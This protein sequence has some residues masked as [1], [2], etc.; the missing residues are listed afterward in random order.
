M[1]NG[2]S[3]GRARRTQPFHAIVHQPVNINTQQ[4]L[5]DIDSIVAQC[6]S[7]NNAPGS[8]AP[9]QAEVDDQ[10]YEKGL[11]MDFCNVTTPGPS[12]SYG[13]SVATNFFRF[14]QL[15]THLYVYNLEMIRGLNTA[16][17]EIR[18][19]KK[20][21]KLLV[22]A[23]LPA[24]LPILGANLNWASDGTLLYSTT[25]LYDPSQLPNVLNSGP[26]QYHNEKFDQLPILDVRMSLAETIAMPQNTVDLFYAPNG[27]KRD[28][29]MQDRLKN[30]L[31][32]FLTS[33]ARSRPAN[34]VTIGARGD[35]KLF[36]TQH[37]NAITYDQS[38][39]VI[40]LHRQ[41]DNDAP[42]DL[43]NH[44]KSALRALRG[45]VLSVRPGSNELLVNINTAT[46]PFFR[47]ITLGDYFRIYAN[48]NSQPSV[49]GKSLLGV[50]VRIMYQPHAGPWP[51]PT[52]S[53][54]FVAE[55]GRP[56]NQQNCGDPSVRN[57]TVF[58]WYTHTGT[59]HQSHELWPSARLPIQR[60]DICINVG[61][62]SRHNEGNGAVWIP[63]HQLQIVEY[64][65]FRGILGA[66]ETT[67]MVNAA[68]RDSDL[69]MQHI[70]TNALRMLRLTGNPNP[71][72]NFSVSIGHIPISVP[73]RWLV[74]P[75][76]QYGRTAQLPTG[77]A[78]VRQASWNLAGV[79]FVATGPVA[80]LAA[81]NCTGRNM[82][83]EVGELRRRLN[84][85]GLCHHSI[86]ITLQAL[87]VHMQ[88]GPQLEASILR[89][90]QRLPISTNLPTIFFGIEKGFDIYSAIKRVA[91]LQLGR[92]TV[93]STLGNT[94]P[95]KA[96]NIATKWN[97]K[98]G[99]DNHRLGDAAFACL[100]PRQV[101]SPA[102]TMVLG[103]D[104]THPGPSAET[105]CPSIAAVVGSVDDNFMQ[106]PGSMRLQRGRQEE[107]AELFDMVKE[108][109]VDW[110]TA[111]QRLPTRILFYRDGVSESQYETLRSYEI[112]QIQQAFNWA[113]DWLNQ[114]GSSA[115]A[116][117]GSSNPPGDTLRTPWP[118]PL[119]PE[120]LQAEIQTAATSQDVTSEETVSTKDQA[121]SELHAKEFQNVKF[122][123][124][125]PCNTSF[126]LTYVVVAKRH[127][128]R[129]Y[130]L[131]TADQVSNVNNNVN[132]NVK[133]GLVVDQVVTHPTSFDF[134]L[135]SHNP[136]IGTGRAAHYFC[137]T[138]G[139]R[140][141]TQ[142]LQT[143]THNFCYAFARAT[144]G[145]SYCA[146]AY[147]ADRLCERGRVYLRSW[148]TGSVLPA[149]KQSAGVDVTRMKQR[150]T[151]EDVRARVLA[152]LRDSQDYRPG[153]HP[154]PPQPPTKYGVM[155]RNPWHENMDGVMFYL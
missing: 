155:R 41:D 62:H 27:T 63:A 123:Q 151:I 93:C 26:F 11:R 2:G 68:R 18:V 100:R 24:H 77:V 70:D 20:A 59:M 137:L 116:P 140:L 111:H 119:S 105:G 40:P 56:A 98:T 87:D 16:G 129:F 38:S 78:V 58:N 46:S 31:N 74:P 55:I 48:P 85:H 13:G 5:T 125:P 90:I 86:P 104:V 19:A 7:R 44:R 121:R 75:T 8:N 109:L 141:S 117:G 10:K 112:P 110:H 154:V 97:I 37:L 89:G 146:P 84:A 94:T 30:G 3:G 34:I 43:V 80:E 132:N 54:R 128:T 57:L 36:S 17:D 99:C 42:I 50:K 88:R 60:N 1:Q 12:A 127:N 82:N 25:P 126:E 130:P 32:A 83:A 101:G 120:A 147:Y 9:T 114:P 131:R 39:R 107:I 152:F 53:H 96:S 71:L 29:S 64:Q 115:N 95:A 81:L 150:E 28:S 52:A 6:L 113:Q 73:S 23:Q 76:V 138:N 92:H 124:G 91:E 4:A 149:R 79:R 35:K 66:E 142:D 51:N 136:I 61:K 14:T 108:R 15:P 103:A 33:D 122:P 65:P 21:D 144:K 22:L 118:V 135:Q 145:V 49:L 67:A 139:M 106:F 102:T 143:V 133:P 69:N 45:Y 148:L 153:P 72:V 134:Y 47:V